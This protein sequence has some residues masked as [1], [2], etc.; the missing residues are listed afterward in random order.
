MTFNLISI[1]PVIDTASEFICRH[2]LIDPHTLINTDKWHPYIS[3]KI[4]FSPGMLSKVFV[5]F[6]TKRKLIIYQNT[7]VFQYQWL[8]RYI[9]RIAEYILLFYT[10]RTCILKLIIHF[11]YFESQDR[12]CLAL[13][14]MCLPG[15]V[16]DGENSGFEFS[17]VNP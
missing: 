5:S 9:I 15:S 8:K 4:T 6:A 2:S 3:A 17:F 12:C 13:R 10:Y 11:M 16:Y 1:L 7:T 14:F